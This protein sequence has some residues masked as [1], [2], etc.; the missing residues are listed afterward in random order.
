MSAIEALQEGIEELHAIGNPR[1]LLQAET[2]ADLLQKSGRT[3]DAIALL[4][5]TADMKERLY[6]HAS[7]GGYLWLRV[8]KITADL[9]RAS[10]RVEEAAL[11][12]NELAAYL[13]VADDDHAIARALRTRKQ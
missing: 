13:A 10:G 3:T 12:E 9:Y 4:E 1:A 5:R 7:P 6:G 2:L 8:R 11:I